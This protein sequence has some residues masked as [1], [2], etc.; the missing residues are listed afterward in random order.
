V[1]CLAGHW[2]LTLIN[3]SYSRGRDQEDGGSKLA[4]AK[5]SKD[6]ILKNSPQNKG[7]WSRPS[8]SPNTE[9]K[10]KKCVLSAY[11]D[12]IPY[13]IPIIKT[14]NRAW[15]LT[16]VILALRRLRKEA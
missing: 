7:W 13:S 5:S 15:W 12:W 1:C 9:K 6:P 14:T 2:W 11:E 10:K 16:L 4:Q 3:P 8:S